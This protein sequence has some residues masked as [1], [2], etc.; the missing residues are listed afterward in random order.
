M[1]TA[2][3]D[4]GR[5]PQFSGRWSEMRRKKTIF[6]NYLPSED[7]TPKKFKR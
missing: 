4:P 2:G 7:K 1:Y 6:I 3:A 5:L